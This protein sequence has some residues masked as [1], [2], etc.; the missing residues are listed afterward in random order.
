MDYTK[1]IGGLFRQVRENAQYQRFPSWVK[2]CMFIGL[3]PFLLALI[4]LTISYYCINFLCKLISAPADYLNCFLKQ[5][6]E[7]VKHL[8]QAILYWIAFPIIFIFKVLLSFLSTYMYVIWFLIM[9]ITYLVTLGG[10]DWQPYL[11]DANY[12]AERKPIA[13]KPSINTAKV[14]TIIQISLFIIFLV[15]ILLQVIPFERRVHDYYYGYYY[16]PNPVPATIGRIFTSL[17]EIITVVGIICIFGKAKEISSSI[18]KAKKYTNNKSIQQITIPVSITKIGDYAFYGC[19]NL[20]KIFYDGTCDEWNLI[21]KGV[22]WNYGTPAKY[23]SCADGD[24]LL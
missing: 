17:Y 19:D 9:C 1:N 4:F 8:T 20:T 16:A 13:Y 23:V 7:G 22:L 11:F 5:E 12:D 15:G 3:L 18:I 2:V 24:V 21:E 6:G 10:V 14:W